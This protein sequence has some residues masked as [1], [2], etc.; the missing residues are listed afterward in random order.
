LAVKKVAWR[1][2]E[3]WLVKERDNVTVMR[4]LSDQSQTI[5]LRTGEQ[6]ILLTS[7]RELSWLMERY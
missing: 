6:Q 7:D 5:S 4:K 3:R 1:E 2:A